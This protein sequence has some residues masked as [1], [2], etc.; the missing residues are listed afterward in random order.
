MKKFYKENRVF[1]IL[2][3]IALVCIAI[4]IWIFAGYI[5]DSS[6]GNKYGNR[7]DGIKDVEIKDDKIEEMEA[8]ILEMEK[9]ED[10]KIN[11]HGKLVNFNIYFG[12]DASLEETQ[13]VS[14]SCIEFFEEDYLNF[15]DLQFFVI[16]PDTEDPTT[17]ETISNSIIGYKKAG[18]TTITWS[19]NAKK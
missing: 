9:V 5:L 6:A 8:A 12:T 4:I 17:G 11:L 10:V 3:G 14:I 1:V 19:N 2:M 16:K 18:E 13:N 7:L 15:Y